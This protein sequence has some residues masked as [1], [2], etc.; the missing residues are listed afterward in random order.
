LPL[1]A[2]PWAT[3]LVFVIYDFI[4]QL[5]KEG[6]GNAWVA[7]PES[8]IVL[9]AIFIVLAA[10]AGIIG[11]QLSLRLKTTTWAVISSMATL[12]GALG[13]LGFCGY[14]IFKGGGPVSAVFGSLSP[15]TAIMLMIAPQDMLEDPTEYDPGSRVVAMIFSLVAAGLYVLLIWLMYVS[16]VK[17]FDMTIRRQQR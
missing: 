16:M 2:L 3:C 11:M 13:I 17:N 15:M 6:S 12:F 8:I 5:N 4:R 1:M 9:P 10:F 14:S 7:L